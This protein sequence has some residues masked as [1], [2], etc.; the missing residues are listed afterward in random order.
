M[1]QEEDGALGG[2]EATGEEEET[3]VAAAAKAATATCA[4]VSA[5]AATGVLQTEWHL[6][7]HLRRGQT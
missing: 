7:T 2:E 1:D 6:S 3:K 4:S 5:E